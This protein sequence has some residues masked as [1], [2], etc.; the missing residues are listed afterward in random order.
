[1]AIST[2][3]SL[4]TVSFKV[5]TYTSTWLASGPKTLSKLNVRVSYFVPALICVWDG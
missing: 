3:P 2:H 1:M 4:Y 5:T